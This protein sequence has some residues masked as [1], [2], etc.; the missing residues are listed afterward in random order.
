M[1]D[2]KKMLKIKKKKLSKEY[3]NTIFYNIE[4]SYNKNGEVFI[5][6]LG[7]STIRDFNNDLMLRL[8]SILRRIYN[9]LKFLCFS[10]FNPIIF[11]F[12]TLSR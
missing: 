2:N 9:G 5:A 1:K 10:N 11:A 7:F 6:I 4:S 12:I 8:N 3:K